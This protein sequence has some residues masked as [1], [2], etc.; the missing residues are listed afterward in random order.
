MNITNNLYLGLTTKSGD[1]LTRTVAFADIC[2]QVGTV[3]SEFGIDGATIIRG[4]GI[5]KGVPEHSVRI[6]ICTD[7]AVRVPDI[8]RRLADV[9]KQECVAVQA[10]APLDFISGS[11][12]PPV[13]APV[14]KGYTIKV[15]ARSHRAVAEI[16][17]VLKNG[18][19]FNEIRHPFSVERPDGHTTHYTPHQQP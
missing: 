19:A 6:T 5:W 11:E 3:L 1:D 7:P 10:D 17:R 4:L 13:E 9:F 18:H 8:A 16:C 15:T 14:D 2:R 12:A